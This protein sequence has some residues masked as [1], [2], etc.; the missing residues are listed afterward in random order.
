[1]GCELESHPALVGLRDHLAVARGTERGGEA[2]LAIALVEDGKAIAGEVLQPQQRRGRRR[3][4]HDRYVSAAARTRPP[5]PRSTEPRPSNSTGHATQ[6]IGQLEARILALGRANTRL[7]HD[8]RHARRQ[9]SQLRHEAD[10]WKDALRR[11]A[12]DIVDTMLQDE[13]GRAHV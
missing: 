9:A 6:R 12:P 3:V 10:K 5:P 7:C 11:H 13:I 4:A 8:L 2:V 1:M